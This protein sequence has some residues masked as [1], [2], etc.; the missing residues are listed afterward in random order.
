MSLKFFGDRMLG[1]LSK[2]LR[3]LG[4][5]ILY[6]PDIP[7][8]KILKLCKNEDRVL[9]TRDKEMIQKAKKEKIKFFFLKSDN[10][11]SQLK[12]VRDRFSISL[13]TCYFFS[14][15][16]ECNGPLKAVNKETVKNNVPEY[17]Y[18]TKDK[19]L[20]CCSCGKVYWEGTHV[21]NIMKE[22]RKV[23]EEL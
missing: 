14:R 20:L 4:F 15:C 21:E 10:W 18:L 22:F 2:K 17:V 23:F 6:F 19:F 1:K 7:E 11:R 3:V 8:E 9:L 16:P 13:N 12:A 5:D